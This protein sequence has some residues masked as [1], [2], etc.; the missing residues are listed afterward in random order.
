VLLGD[1]DIEAPAGKAAVEVV[2]PRAA[3]HRR[4]DRDDLAVLLCLGDERLGEVVGVG[5][6]LGGDLELLPCG[7]VELG[8]AC[9]PATRSHYGT[10]LSSND[11][12]AK[13]IMSIGCHCYS[14]WYLSAARSA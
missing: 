7:R 14:P 3:A 9:K 4:V 11:T 12:A 13:K 5:L 8:N 1:P 2:E 6:R 10:D